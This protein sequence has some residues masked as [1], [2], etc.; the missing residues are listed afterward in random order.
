MKLSKPI[1]AFGKEVTEIEMKKPDGGTIRRCGYPFKIENTRSGSQIQHINADA[2]AACIS[3]LAAIP[4]SS[5]DTLSPDD[6]MALTSEV[7]GFFGAG[8]NQETS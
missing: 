7:L 2:V 3:E 4:M 6:F 5:V 8:P 1:H